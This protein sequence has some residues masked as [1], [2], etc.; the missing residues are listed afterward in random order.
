MG[1]VIPSGLNRTQSTTIQPFNLTNEGLYNDLVKFARLSSAA[2][3][4]STI[5]GV[6]EGKLNE[7]CTD[8]SCTQAEDDIVVVD[9]IDSLSH[10]LIMVQDSTKQL[11][12]DFEG[13]TTIIDWIIDF[14]YELVAFESYGSTKGLDVVGINATNPTV[15]EGYQKVSQNFFKHGFAKLE[16]LF[17]QYP[18][19]QLVLTGHSLGGALSSLVGVQLYLMGYK[20]AIVTY[21]STKVFGASF[22]EWIDQEFHTKD[23]VSRLQQNDVSRIEA[24]TITRV[25]HNGDVIATLPA[26]SV[27]YAHVGSEFYIH[28]TS[29]PHE[30][31]S[32]QIRG[33][34]YA[35]YENQQMGALLIN[36]RPMLANFFKDMYVLGPHARYFGNIATC[37]PAAQFAQLLGFEY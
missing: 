5:D 16:K 9:V 2:Y 31:D 19:Y 22:A 29:L 12:I 36:W 24:G 1:S 15:H 37:T 17:E 3:C 20:P 34:F 30:I 4:I 13:S 21:A 10:A 25:F 28:K 23:Y 35:G 32:V 8:N 7:G 26:A 11:I 6:E 14:K 18:D 27:G 33:S